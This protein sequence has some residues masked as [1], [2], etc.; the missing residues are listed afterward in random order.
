MKGLQTARQDLRKRIT[1]EEKLPWDELRNNKLG[2]RFRRQHSV[3][4]FVADFFCPSQRFIIELDGNQH[5]E[6]KE[7]DQERTEFFESLEIKVIRFWN[8][9]VR[10]NLLGVVDKIKKELKEQPHPASECHP[11]LD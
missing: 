5:S 7:Y 1:P 11:L 4:N 3:S 8:E 9:E 10:D 2:C 6:N